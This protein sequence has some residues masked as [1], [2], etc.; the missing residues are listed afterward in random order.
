MKEFI[1]FVLFPH[2][3]IRIKDR[4]LEVESA[5]LYMLLGA[6]IASFRVAYEAKHELL[7]EDLWVSVIRIL[8]YLPFLIGV[9]M[10][11]YSY[12]K[13]NVRHIDDGA[14][15][16]RTQLKLLK[17][18]LWKYGQRT[19]YEKLLMNELEDRWL[20][21]YG[22]PF[23]KIRYVWFQGY[24]PVLLPLLCGLIIWLFS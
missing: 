18:D 16:W 24:Q 17:S 6:M 1:K 20:Q 21:W 2:Y 5:Y 13:P 3:F 23:D 10:F 7:F 15:H 11:I 19:K 22:V 9:A 4:F 12:Y 8:C 14:P